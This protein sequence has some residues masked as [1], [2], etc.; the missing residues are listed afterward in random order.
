MYSISGICSTFFILVCDDSMTVARQGDQAEI[1]R[2]I[3]AI[4]LECAPAFGVAAET[5]SR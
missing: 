3:R 1:V 2:L 4:V 5:L